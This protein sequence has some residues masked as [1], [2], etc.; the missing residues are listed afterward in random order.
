MIDSK[1]IIQYIQ[2]LYFKKYNQAAPIELLNKWEKIPEQEILIRLDHLY[3][4]WDYNLVQRGLIVQEF[5]AQQASGKN[6]MH[7]A[8]NQLFQNEKLTL[9]VKEAKAKSLHINK[10]PN[11]GSKKARWIFRF[12]KLLVIAA[13]I[14]GA[15]LAFK[16]YQ[17]THLHNIYTLTERVLIRTEFGKEIGTL[18][19]N[20]TGK[21]NSFQELTVLDNEIYNRAIDSS[22]KLYEHRKVVMQKN[23]FL[24]FVQNKPEIF[25]YVNAKFVVD[26]KEEYE[27]YKRI[28]GKL[29]ADD[30]KRLQLKHRQIIASCLKR[31][32]SIKNLYVISSCSGI[33]NKT[34][35]NTSGI[36]VDELILDNK[37]QIMARLSDG[38]YYLF[39]GDVNSNQYEIPK[40]IGY[41]ETPNRDD[42][43]IT[44]DFLFKY[45]KKKDTYYLTNCK[46]QM[47]P[48]ES[49]NNS[50]GE[51]S[52]FKKTE[53]AE[54]PLQPL[55]EFTEEAQDAI[56]TV[57]DA[58]EKIFN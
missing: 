39:K 56:Q 12:I 53:P 46:G 6:D 9:E 49:V 24:D 25:A 35:K 37:Y 21:P 11:G 51:I 33:V 34:I 1:N 16:Y 15:Y 20:A 32:N 57:T 23:N 3:E 50:L 47:L 29:Q 27:M 13:I 44:G 19:L 4:S 5:V 43:F 45:D 22:G 30:N 55:T 38:Y 14:G 7:I 48:F 40:R 52:F 17:F 42:E 31:N 28:F 18:D 2:F 10:V 54:S 41:N 8:A 26:S 58:V 36:I